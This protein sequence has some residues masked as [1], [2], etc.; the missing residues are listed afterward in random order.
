MVIQFVNFVLKK[1]MTIYTTSYNQLLVSKCLRPILNPEDEGARIS[2]NTLAIHPPIIT[3]KQ[4]MKLY[5]TR[6]SS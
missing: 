6:L 1:A 5:C 4:I 3:N 2:K